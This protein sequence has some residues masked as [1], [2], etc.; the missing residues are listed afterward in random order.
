VFYVGGISRRHITAVAPP[1][2]ED[3]RGSTVGKRPYPRFALTFTLQ[4]TWSNRI[5]G[6]GLAHCSSPVGTPPCYDGGSASDRP[7][8]GEVVGAVDLWIEGP[9]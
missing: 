9:N 7:G 8:K 1:W 4:S 2:T 3:L 6:S 5:R